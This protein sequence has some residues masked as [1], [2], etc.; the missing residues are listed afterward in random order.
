MVNPVFSEIHEAQHAR[1]SQYANPGEC[2]MSRPMPPYTVMAGCAPVARLGGSAVARPVA[3]P[4]PIALAR[5]ERV[6]S[7]R[8]AP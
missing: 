8:S 4:H 3:L 5:S 7:T 1:L 2:T 6:I